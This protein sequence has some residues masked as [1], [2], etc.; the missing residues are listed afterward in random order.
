LLKDN[1]GPGDKIVESSVDTPYVYAFAAIK[2]NGAR[3]LLLINKRDRA[4]EL[5]VPGEA[6]HVF[7]VDQATKGGPYAVSK[8]HGKAIQLGGLAVAVVDFK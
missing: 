8:P 5:A 4:F 7:A 6:T 2:P 1:F 3:K